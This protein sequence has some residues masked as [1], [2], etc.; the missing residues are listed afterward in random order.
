MSSFLNILLSTDKKQ[1]VRIRRSLLA[2]VVFCV[3]LLVC[4]FYHLWIE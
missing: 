4:S 2:S 3:S 1:R